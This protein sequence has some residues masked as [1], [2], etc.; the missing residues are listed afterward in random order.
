MC[1]AT[2]VKIIKLKGSKATV[3][4]LGEKL[5]VDVSLLKNVSAGDYLLAK[6]ELAIQKLAPEEAREIL[7]LVE[8]CEHNS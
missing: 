3:D 8:E 7:K 6:G 5:D 2:P 4:A 1:I